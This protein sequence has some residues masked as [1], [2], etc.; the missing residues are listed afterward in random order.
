V[1]LDDFNDRL[2]EIFNANEDRDLKP[3]LLAIYKILPEFDTRP[4]SLEILLEIV[5]R[6]L[7]EAPAEMPKEW[8]DI[9]HAPSGN[10]LIRKF[11]SAGVAKSGIKRENLDAEGIEFT[12]NAIRFQC[13]ELTRMEGKQLEN[14]FRWGG[15]ISDTGHDWYNFTAA[16]VLHCGTA[17]MIDNKENTDDIDWSF[18]GSLLE[19]GRVYE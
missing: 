11:T 17:C 15:V 14:K 2:S 6:G 19:D 7:T 10:R 16:E 5:E 12:I 4:V 18:L 9:E 1:K 13:A 8:L 3:F